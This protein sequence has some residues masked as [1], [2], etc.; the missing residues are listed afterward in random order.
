LKDVL[1]QGLGKDSFG[2]PGAF[3]EMRRF[4]RARMLQIEPPAG[5]SIHLAVA[6][7]A[8]LRLLGLCGLPSLEPGAGLLIPECRSVHTIAMRFPVDVVFVLPDGRG[9]ALVLAVREAVGP[10]RVAN[11]GERGA[12]VAAIEIAAGEAMRHGIAAGARL[13]LGP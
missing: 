13:A 2:P 5:P 7:R 9:H 3:L 4:R 11:A 12:R 6:E 8:W 1:Q 10:L